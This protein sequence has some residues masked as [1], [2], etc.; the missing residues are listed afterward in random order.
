MRGAR[1]INYGAIKLGGGQKK[2][3]QS[4]SVRMKNF[5]RYINVMS[6]IL[7][8]DIKYVFPI[9]VSTIIYIFMFLGMLHSLKN[10]TAIWQLIF[11]CRSDLLS[12]SNLFI[13]CSNLCSFFSTYF[14]N[15]LIPFLIIFSKEMPFLNHLNY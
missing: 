11:F 3:I 14:V 2:I 5:L 7:G 13:N 9:Y 6:A 4:M 10:K 8:H 12:L 1:W 15:V